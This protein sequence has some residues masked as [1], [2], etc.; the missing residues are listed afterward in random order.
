MEKLNALR[1]A[2]GMVEREASKFFDKGNQAAGTRARKHLLEARN[3]CSELRKVIQEQKRG[4]K[5][6][7][8]QKKANGEQGSGSGDPG[9]SQG[10]SS[11]RYPF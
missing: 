8:A 7:R 1:Q 10:G 5:D 2:F 9:N 3:L 6:T 11:Y 4:M